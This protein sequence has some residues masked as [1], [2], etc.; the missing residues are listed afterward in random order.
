MDVEHECVGGDVVGDDAAQY[1][2]G[3]PRLGDSHGKSL[4]DDL[5]ACAAEMFDDDGLGVLELHDG[6]HLSLADADVG[7][8]G[9]F[10]D[11]HYGL[12]VD[13]REAPD[14]AAAKKA[15]LVSVAPPPAGG[16]KRKA[17]GAKAGTQGDKK[18]RRCVK[19][20]SCFRGVTHHCRTGRWESHICTSPPGGRGAPRR[21]SARPS[22]RRGWETPASRTDSP[23]RLS[24]P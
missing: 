6:E 13:V 23:V 18:P 5:D 24:L 10:A 21:G 19:S 20:T 1:V 2:A 17:Q 16:T 14:V 8:K 15:V 12:S 7:L 11:M 22:P 3:I 9:A 4:F